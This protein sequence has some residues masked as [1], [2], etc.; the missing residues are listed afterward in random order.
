MSYILYNIKEKRLEEIDKKGVMDML[1]NGSHRVPLDHEIKDKKIK[2]P[3]EYVEELKKMVSKIENKVPLYD[4]YTKN[5]YLINGSI[6]YNKVTREHYRFPDKYLVD[7]LRDRKK[8]IKSSIDPLLKREYR[9][10]TIMFDFFDNFDMKILESTYEHVLYENASELGKNLTICV[11]PSFIPRF[12]YI[13]PYYTRSEL[14]NLGL[15]MGIIKPSGMKYDSKKTLELCDPVKNNDI[16]ATII[17]NHQNYIA[18]SNKIGLIQYYSMQGSYFMNQYLRGLSKYEIR[19]DLLEENILSMWKLIEHAPEFDK[20]YTL[21]RFISNDDFLSS[22]QIGDTFKDDGFTSTTRDPFYRSNTY[23]FGIILIKIKIPKKVKGVALCIEPYSQF[24]EEQEII[25]P[26][27]SILRLDSRDEN[28]EYYHTDNMY[29]SQIKTKYEFTYIGK[30]KIQLEERQPYPDTQTVDF[31]NSDASMEM[32]TVREKMNYFVGKY[33]DPKYQFKTYIGNN[34]HDII[35]EGYDSTGAYKNYYAKTTNEGIMMYTLIDNHIAFMIELCEE[36]GMN[37]MYANFYFKYSSSSF[38]NR[39]SD[40]DLIV[41]LSKIAYYFNIGN[42]Y[43][44]CEYK[45]CD[46]MKKQTYT[47]GNLCVDVYEYLTNGKKR[48]INKDI[49]IDSLELRPYFNYHDLN[50][51]KTYD[52]MKILNREDQDEIYKIYDE[53]YKINYQNK[54]D[55]IA[56]FYLW[57]VDNYC[58]LLDVLVSKFHRVYTNTNPFETDFYIF[59][60][61]AFLYNKNLIDEIPYYE[62]DEKGKYVFRYNINIPKNQYRVLDSRGPRVPTNR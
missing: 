10:L 5:L 51:L 11:R 43:I 14:I 12:K 17:L 41:L 39:I 26:P 18:D 27:L 20:S 21:Y 28:T 19:N 62:V 48:F 47:G 50:R 36:E 25:L 16:S 22:L 30:E 44:Y 59:D 35:I 60:P 45:Y 40:Y 61:F 9:K 46:F 53:I 55:N 33:V 37:Y 23:K 56:S 42:V 38:K 34:V 24:K 13:N 29:R 8:E 2:D 31:L 54:N 49:T 3:N 6:I 15:N 52:V 58:L 1:Y 32:S 4:E 57:L 7:K